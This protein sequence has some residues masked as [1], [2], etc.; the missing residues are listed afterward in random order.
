MK[1]LEYV[2][3]AKK[4]SKNFLIFVPKMNEG[5]MGLEQHEVE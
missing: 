2:L 1:L 4:T 3:C 5:V